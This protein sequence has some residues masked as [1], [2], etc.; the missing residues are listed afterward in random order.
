MLRLLQFGLISALSAPALAA[1]FKQ[2]ALPNTPV[3]PTVRG[4]GAVKVMQHDRTAF[5]RATQLEL[6]G[7][8]V[9]VAGGADADPAFDLTNIRDAV[10][11]SDG[12]I[13]AYSR[14][15][16]RFLL[17]AANGQPQRRIGRV[18]K[19]PGEFIRSTGLVLMRSDTIFLYDD[20]NR[21]LNWALVDRGVVLNKPRGKG[22]EMSGSRSAGALSTGEIILSSASLVPQGERDR[23]TRPL[24]D[25]A[26]LSRDGSARALTG[27]PGMEVGMALMRFPKRPY[28]TSALVRFGL[29]AVVTAWDL[30]VASGTGDRY[31]IDLRTP[32]DSPVARIMVDMQR[33]KVTAAM[34][35]AALA[36]E[37]SRVRPQP[38]SEEVGGEFLKQF[39]RETPTADSLPPYSAFHV[40]PNK[41]LWVIDYIA[42]DDNG[43]SATAFRKDGAIV[44][45]LRAADKGVPLAFGDDRVVIRSED[46]DGV[47]SLTVRRIGVASAKPK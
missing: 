13:A 42:P 11:L 17:F 37:L 38:N 21:R 23:I 12:R 35:D 28:W 5:S 26:L 15:G 34:R 33:R 40:T 2:A 10:L 45:R 7:A 19:G 41:T 22:G 46:D 16:S 4:E 24:A 44:G 47:I 43:W 9:T 31:R 25:I 3:M 1:Q 30:V 27:V 39:I 8:P 14:I 32:N 36:E 18:G 20:G 29:R 6:V